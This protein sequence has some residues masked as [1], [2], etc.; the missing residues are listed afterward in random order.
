MVKKR[1]VL[2]NCLRGYF[3][4]NFASTEAAW[5]Y[6]SARFLLSFPSADGRI[7]SMKVWEENKYQI[8]EWVTCRQDTTYL[9]KKNETAVRRLCHHSNEF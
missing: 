3:E 1:F 6:L 5:Q 7:V 8:E 4:G 9:G 2:G